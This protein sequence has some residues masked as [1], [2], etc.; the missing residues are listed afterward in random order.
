[1]RGIWV[2]P[3]ALGETYTWAVDGRQ[4]TLA[5]PRTP[6]DFVSDDE[7]EVP[8][9]PAWVPTARM[10][11][12]GDAVAV[13]L[14]RVDV[15]FDGDVSAS[16]KVEARAKEEGGDDTLLNQF[17]EAAEHIWRPAFELGVQ[18]T[19]A[20]LA[21]VRVV[22]QQP[23]LGIK[24]EPPMQYGRSHLVD[25]DANVRLMSWGPL[26]SLTIRSGQLA[27]TK[28]RLRQVR[29]LVATGDEPSAAEVL[30][31][32][33]RFLVQEAE[34]VDAQ[35]AVL[36]AAIACEIKSKSVMHA[37]ASADKRA[38]TDLVLRRVSNLPQ[39]LAEPLEAALGVS[40]RAANPELYGHARQLSRLRNL[41]AHEGIDVDERTAWKLVVHAGQ[42]FEWLDA[43]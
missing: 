9:V 30:L 28:D 43:L 12:S 29:E 11:G 33:A 26:Q 24:V 21:H 20:W 23:W 25:L 40:L 34:V 10:Q 31:A 3:D 5:L 15:E 4:V 6:T 17:G 16:Q 8:N 18:L 32:D 1:M 37:K 22:S 7:P 14:L 2:Q 35:R 27:L 42:L 36:L 39:L 38:L 41:V 13:Q 19:H